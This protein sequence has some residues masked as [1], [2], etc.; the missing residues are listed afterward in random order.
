MVLQVGTPMG[1]F[2]LAFDDLAV[3]HRA[4][5][6]LLLGCFARRLCRDAACRGTQVPG[7]RGSGESR[8]RRFR[9]GKRAGCA[10]PVIAGR[11]AVAPD[12]VAVFHMRA[13]DSA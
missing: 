5:L 7:Q 9:P 6:A 1:I 11:V 8:L 13:W 12:G 2:A 10:A 4:V 3:W